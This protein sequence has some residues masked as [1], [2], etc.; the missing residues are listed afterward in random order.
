MVH[1]VAFALPCVL[2]RE[3]VTCYGLLCMTL[4]CFVCGKGATACHGLLRF[5]RGRGKLSNVTVYFA[6]LSFALFH[7]ARAKE[8]LSHVTICFALVCFASLYV[9]LLCFALLI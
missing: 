1:C 4:L 8:K 3:V 5:V 2:E 6:L 9:A 7:F